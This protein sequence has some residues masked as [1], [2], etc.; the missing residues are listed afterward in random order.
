MYV[1]V[2][3]CSMCVFVCMN[4]GM[5]VHMYMCVEQETHRERDYQLGNDGRM[6][7]PGERKG[8]GQEKG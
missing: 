7:A 4:R 5:F 2:S 8:G 3:V 6:K 1:F